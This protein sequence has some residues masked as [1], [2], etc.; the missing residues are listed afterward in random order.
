M[1]LGKACLERRYACTTSSSQPGDAGHFDIASWNQG[2]EMAEVPPPADK[3]NME[4]VLTV[5]VE[6]TAE[7]KTQVVE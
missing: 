1:F 7:E 3:V 5:V 6:T 4:L 2:V